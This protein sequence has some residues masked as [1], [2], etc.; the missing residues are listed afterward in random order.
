VG[1][2][3]ARDFE[4]LEDGVRRHAYQLVLARP[5]DYPA[6]AIRDRGYQ[7]V[8]TTSGDG[9]VRFIVPKNSP[10]KSLREASGKRIAFPED[11][12]YAARVAAAT[13][14][15]IGVDI[16]KEKSVQYFRDQAAIG[17]VLEA[18]LADV[19]AV[20]SYSGVGRDWEKKGGRVLLDGP[21]QPYM[22]LVAS[23][24]VS[25]QEI[26]QVRAALLALDQSPAGQAVLKRVG[27]G[28][29]EQRDPGDLARLLQWLGQ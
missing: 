18:G 13:L 29:F 24:K 7:L 11:I 28:G 17:F 16:R 20:M 3:L 15:D 27:V 1:F 12:S 22:P 21:R 9:F 26:A 2:F 10:L 23:P 4:M 14:R 8:T 5:S 6:R 25:A 19:G